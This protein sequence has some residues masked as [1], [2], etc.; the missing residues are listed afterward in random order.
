MRRYWCEIRKDL[1]SGR[2]IFIYPDEL[3]D[4]NEARF[5]FS[6]ELQ[7]RNIA[8]IKGW[9]EGL[10]LVSVEVEQNDAEKLRKKIKNEISPYIKKRY[11]NEWE[12]L[13]ETILNAYHDA[14]LKYSVTRWMIW[15]MT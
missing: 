2:I 13:T 6:G 3:I 12:E 4:P 7:D 10:N 1:D 11:P 8:A 15:G 14:P 9:G 5:K